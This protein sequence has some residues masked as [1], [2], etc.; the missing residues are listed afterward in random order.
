MAVSHTKF[1]D[2][3]KYCSVYSFSGKPVTCNIIMYSTCMKIFHNWL[4]L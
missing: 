1:N 4:Q 3:T 2:I